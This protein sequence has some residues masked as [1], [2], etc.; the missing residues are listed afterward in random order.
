MKLQKTQRI[1]IISNGDS[2]NAQLESDKHLS[3]FIKAGTNTYS[4]DWSKSENQPTIKPLAFS[5]SQGR[6]AVVFGSDSWYYNNVEI[7]FDASGVSTNPKGMFKRVALTENGVQ[8]PALR[9]ISNIISLS[10][11]DNDLL[12]CKCKVKVGVKEYDIQPQRDIRLQETMGDP[13]DGFIAAQNGGVLTNEVD[14][15][16]CTAY[17]RKGGS[18]IVQGVTYKWFKRGLTDYIAVDSD[19]NKPNQRTFTRAEIDANLIIKVE[20]YIDNVQVF[21]VTRSLSDLTDPLEIEDSIVKGTDISTDNDSIT[22]AYRVVRKNTDIVIPTASNFN[23]SLQKV[24][25]TEVRKSSGKQFIL[26]G[27]DYST[28]GVKQLDIVTSIEVEV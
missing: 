2:I 3:Q 13:Y 22:Y 26:T 16:T 5:Q 24:D 15:T 7:K 23:F 19:V 14:K 25:G 12:T 21:S 8:V 4:P 6:V 20:F 10:N 28:A 1:T 27:K 17:L 18:D 11:T 9:I